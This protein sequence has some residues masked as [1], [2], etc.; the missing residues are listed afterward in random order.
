[1]DTKS[2]TQYTQRGLL[3]V[4][5]GLDRA[6]K[7]TQ[8]QRLL[9]SLQ[10][11][12]YRVKLF[13]FPNRT[14]PIGQII[15]E[16]LKS[17]PDDNSNNIKNMDNASTKMDNSTYYYYRALHLL[18]SANRWECL[19][20][21]ETALQSGIHV[22]IDR[23]VWS[24]IAY[25][26]ARDENK[27]PLS[28]CSSADVGL[29]KPNITI[30]LDID[31]TNQQTR[32]DWGTERNDSVSLQECVSNAY[33]KIMNHETKKHDSFFVKV[34]ANHDASDVFKDVKLIVDR[35]LKELKSD[36]SIVAPFLQME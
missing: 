2:C 14:T 36:D 6:G 29:T 32:G 22:I 9:E 33:K 15:N 26:H 35:R 20:E 34:D 8:S 28:C 11:E 30:F 18:F 31:T 27:F 5:E 16:Y 13:R 3:I 24:G 23:Y 12:G 7:T 10:S 17:K 21:I 25:T 1:M 4:F 19:Y